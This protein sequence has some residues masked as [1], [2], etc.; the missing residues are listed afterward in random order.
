MARIHEVSRRD[1]IKAGAI[2]VAATATPAQAREDDRTA[3]SGARVFDGRRILENYAVVVSTGRV[4]DV[5]HQ[6]QVPEGVTHYHAPDCTILR[7]LIY[8]HFHFIRCQGR[9]VQ[10]HGVRTGRDTWNN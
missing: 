5:V 10:A 2:A 3:Y 9:L 4:L 6:A 7:G 1:F 8:C